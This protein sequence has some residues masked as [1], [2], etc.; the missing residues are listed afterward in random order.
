MH[1][2]TDVFTALSA[3]VLWRKPPS[4]QGHLHSLSAL[5]FL[6]RYVYQ[7]NP[8]AWS[9]VLYSLFNPVSHTLVSFGFRPYW[10]RNALMTPS[11]SASRLHSPAS[12]VRTSMN[13]AMKSSM[14]PFPSNRGRVTCCL[15][16][17]RPAAWAVWVSC[18]YITL[19]SLSSPL[20]P[21][22]TPAPGCASPVGLHCQKL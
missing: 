2:P 11:R 17:S 14:L 22:S 5:K 8:W 3:L 18:V 13:W 16:G 19:E 4:L 21:V 12:S 9:A 20:S 7:S 15:S 6:V 1:K 10:A